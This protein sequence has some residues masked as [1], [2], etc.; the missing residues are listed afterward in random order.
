MTTTDS[1]TPTSNLKPSNL[2]AVPTPVAAPLNGPYP[3]VSSIDVADPATGAI[4]TRFYTYIEPDPATPGPVPMVV[5][6]HGGGGNMRV[7]YNA[8]EL[9]SVPARPYLT[10][11]PQGH[12]PGATATSPPVDGGWN[13]G[14]SYMAY[15]NPN[16]PI[17]DVAF[18]DALLIEIT[19]V[20]ATAGWR[21]D[22]SRT[23]AVGFSNGGMMTYRLAAERSADF[24]AVAVMQASIGGDPDPNDPALPF[25]INHP[26]LHNAEPV[27]LLQI[28]GLLDPGWSLT[29]GVIP[30]GSNPRSDLPVLDGVESWIAYN[31]CDRD[32]SIEPHPEGLLRTWSGGRDETDVSLLTMPAVAHHVPD[33]VLD[34]IEP[35]LLSHT[36]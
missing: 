19:Q 8:L 17:D 12:G 21:I 33:G 9:G 15:Q 18:I 29:D 24:A 20:M 7:M 27:S 2:K 28:H 30:T 13:S 14:Q 25:H 16:G 26:A 22:Q 32:P 6:L 36:K 31:D 35:F 34:L 3:N 1:T 23:Y 10:V 4:T 5:A 11:I